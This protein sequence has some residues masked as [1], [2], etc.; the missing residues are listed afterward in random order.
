MFKTVN[1]YILDLLAILTS[2]G[3]LDVFTSTA[4]QHIFTGL[5]YLFEGA[6]VFGL[7]IDVINHYNIIDDF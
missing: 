2:G 4:L 6:T 3:H 5:D 1:G 7:I